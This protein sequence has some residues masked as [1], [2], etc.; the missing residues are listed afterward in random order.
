MRSLFVLSTLLAMSFL[1]AC[2]QNASKQDSEKSPADT[3]KVEGSY[4]ELITEKGAVPV[5]KLDEMLEGQDSVLVKL[6]GEIAASCQSSGCWM[7]LDMGDGEKLKVTFKDYAFFIPKDSKGKTTVVEGVA[8][9]ELIP[10]ETLRH[11]A[12]DEGKSKEEIAAITEPEWA[13]TFEAKG[14]LIRHSEE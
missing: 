11:Y 5:A 2:N 1:L 6:T 8:R 14:V 12:T 3:V 13:Y 7:D 9:K 10:V 4:G